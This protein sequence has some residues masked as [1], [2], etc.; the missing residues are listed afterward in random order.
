M[1]CSE[2]REKS[3]AITLL[4]VFFLYFCRLIGLLSLLSWH[5]LSVIRSFCHRLEYSIDTH[6]FPVA[7]LFLSVLIV[8]LIEEHLGTQRHG[9]RWL[10]ILHLLIA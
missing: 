6:S 1:A 8:E 4:A 5:A 9:R 10:S 7:P 2:S 3:F